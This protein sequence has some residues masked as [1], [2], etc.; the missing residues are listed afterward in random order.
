MCMEPTDRGTSH[1]C[2][3][4]DLTTSGTH[5]MMDSAIVINIDYKVGKM[6]RLGIFRT[7]QYAG[8]V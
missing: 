8:Q 5:H 3:R 4:M 7:D 1:L 2:S 6:S